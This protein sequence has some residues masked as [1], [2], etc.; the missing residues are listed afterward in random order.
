[1]PI[2]KFIASWHKHLSTVLIVLLAANVHAETLTGRVVYVV[3]G[4]TAIV[5]NAASERHSVRVS[6]IDAPEIAQAF[7]DESRQNLSRLVLNKPVSINYEKIDEF[8]R[9]IGKIMV[10]PPD[11]CPD[12]SEACPKTLDVGL[13][14]IT[15]GLAWW[16]LYYAA[17][18]S[19]EDRHSYE[20]TVYD[21]RVRRVGL[22]S[23]TDPVPPWRWRRRLN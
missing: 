12:A 3:D 21:A 1:M 4:D 22:W 2:T 23:H 9:I 7:G 17:E 5:L 16:Y 15:V 18:Q 14:Q 13:A 8:E 6:G 11:A 10:A 19:A 20:S